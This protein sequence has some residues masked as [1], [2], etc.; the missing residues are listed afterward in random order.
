MS[1]TLTTPNYTQFEKE[2]FITEAVT[3]L[4]SINKGLF[5][6]ADGVKNDVYTFPVF[7]ASPKLNPRTAIPTD[8]STTVLSNKNVT[9]GAFQAYE[10][11]DPTIFENHWHQAELTDLLLA[12]Q[13][14]AT[15][16]NYLGSFYTQKTLVP[17]ETM[18]WMGS[19]SYSTASGGTAETPSSANY[20]HRYFDGIIKQALDVTTPALQ[21]PSPVALTSANIIAKMEAA[22]A[23]VPKAILSS[24]KRYDRLKYIMSVADA[25]K[26]EEA[27]TSTTYKNNN[28]TEK[29]MNQYKSYTIEVVAGLPENTF[30]LCEAVTDPTSN[31]HMA[32]TSLDNLS[33]KIDRLQNNAEVWFYKAIAK[34]GVG[35]AKPSELVI[36]TTQ[37]L[38][39]FSL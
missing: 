24:A 17:V 4:D 19:T 18:I 35:I 38:A 16:E 14:P 7:S 21:V 30:V 31:L 10:V 26:Y 3:G 8:N 6:V 27:L 33:F 32:V 12:R 5:Y 25:Q 39:N 2:F 23:L 34:M 22:K 37:V 28:T 13:L 15:F 20:S 1:A 9:L 29:G 36:Y 11:F